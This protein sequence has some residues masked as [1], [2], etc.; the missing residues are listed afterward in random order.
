MAYGVLKEYDKAI[1]EFSK[2]IELRPTFGEAWH[3]R[4]ISYSEKS[5]Q[6]KAIADYSEAIKLNPKNA[7]AYKDRAIATDLR[8]CT[9]RQVSI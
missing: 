7:A 3:F 5:E 6:D 1:V 8:A 4:G 2:A 9:R